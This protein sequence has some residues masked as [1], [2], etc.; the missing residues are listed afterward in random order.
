[1]S[2]RLLLLVGLIAVL[3]AGAVPRAVAA[4]EGPNAAS[5][6]RFAIDSNASFPDVARTARRHGFVILQSWQHD[7]ARRLKA[8]DPDLKVLA[9]KNLTFVSCAGTEGQYVPQ[10]V[11]CA[12]AQANH[13]DW[14]LTD[15]GGNRLN[16]TGY[17]WAWLMDLG[18]PSYQRAW[19][20][21]VIP[22]LKAGGWDGVF[23]DD[24]NS[25]LR[26]HFDVGRVAR[27]PTDTAWTGATR[28]M[29][30]AVG[31]R[32]RE[33][34]LLAVGNVCCERLQRGIWKDWLPF[35]DGAL[36]EMFTKW[37]NDPAVG[38][39]W[40]WGSDGWS[41]QLE[42]VQ[43][44]ESQGKYF[45]GVSH[46]RADDPRAAIY[47]LGTMLLASQGRSSFSL[48]SD[49]TQETWFAD[50][51]R[52]STLGLPL[53]AYSRMGP[54]YRR[55]FVSGAVVVNPSLSTVHVALGG[56]YSTTG[57]DEVQSLTLAPTSASILLSTPGTVGTPPPPP[58]EP[59]PAP[60]EPPPPPA[61][62]PPTLPAAEVPAPKVKKRPK[63]QFA[64]VLTRP[65]A[66]RVVGIRLNGR[67]V[68][69]TA[70]DGRSVTILG[71]TRAGWRQLGRART[72][73]G[74]AFR[75]SRRLRVDARILRLRAV[76]AHAGTPV[77]SGVLT[78]RIRR[79]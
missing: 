69:A 74:G 66:R 58:A 14:F 44:A 35:L 21:G 54:V 52:A 57:G 26:Y 28:S 2:A 72:R 78:V 61:F 50:Y 8:E 63:V 38:Y 13:P 56:L 7:L 17:P 22:E 64:V 31:P 49:Y 75:I 27:Y 23:M 47:G 76:V 20:D 77:R 40:D 34:G 65:T 37:G 9:Y 79:R 32:I 19:A 59:P 48:A 41:A 55:D 46:S 53:G 60:V 24:T 12:D 29:L 33:A 18:N 39:Q 70:P 4:A 73:A 25:T 43:E 5:F 36:E 10:G 45:L 3:A 62:P 11:R 6:N 1:M 67:L 51:D 71:R 42:Q 68:G 16:S 30:A 15:A